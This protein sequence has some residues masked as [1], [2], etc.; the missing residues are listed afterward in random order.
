LEAE[1]EVTT[2]AAAVIEVATGGATEGAATEGAADE[3]AADER[4]ADEGAADEGA[5]GNSVCVTSQTVVY[6]LIV[7]LCTTGD[8]RDAGQCATLERQDVIV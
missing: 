4:T 3:E 7:L 1:A 6:A 8:W 5:V 2:A